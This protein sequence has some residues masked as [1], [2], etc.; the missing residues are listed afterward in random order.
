MKNAAMAATA[1]R[2]LPTGSQIVVADVESDGTA[3]AL[4]FESRVS[5]LGNEYWAN[6]TDPGAP[7]LLA[8]DIARDFDDMVVTALPEVAA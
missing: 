7:S 8:E 5:V 1:L 3:R 6:I 2:H 4:M